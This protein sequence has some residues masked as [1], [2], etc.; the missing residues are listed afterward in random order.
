M[1]AS[2]HDLPVNLFLMTDMV[3]GH[4]VDASHWRLK[5][6]I[7]QAILVAC[8]WYTPLRRHFAMVL[9]GGL[10]V[11]A[12]TL[13][14]EPVRM[15]V[16]T[17]K[18]I[19]TGDGYLPLFAFGVA[20]HHLVHDRSS[21][22]WRWM[23]AT[24]LFLVVLS[25]TLGQGLIVA[26]SLIVLAAIAM[27]ALKPLGRIRFLVRLGELAFPIYVV[28]FV[29]GFAIIHRLEALG[30]PPLVATLAASSVA[31]ML[32]MVLNVWVERPIQTRG[33]TIAAVLRQTLRVQVR[34]FKPAA[35]AFVFRTTMN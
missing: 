6:E 3:G 28:H 5:I 33:A 18:G 34:P 2:A 8:A 12:T 25:N 14:G 4:A 26:S 22:V 9:A 27:G 15:H 17:L 29:M 10:L 35:S 21:L 19:V 1:T 23:A 11:C 7:G 20:L 31:I 32:G 24:S 13:A 30:A 16:L